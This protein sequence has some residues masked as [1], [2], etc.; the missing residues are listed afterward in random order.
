MNKA[1][2][3]AEKDYDPDG[4]Q[5]PEFLRKISYDQWRD[6]RYE[7]EMALWKGS[8]LFQ[9][10][11]FHPGFIYNRMVKINIIENSQITPVSFSPDVFHYGMNDFKDKV[12][13]NLGFAGFRVRFPINSAAVY[14][15]FLVFLGASYFRAVGQGQSYGLSARGLAVNTAL[16]SGE[17]FPWFREFWLEKPAKEAKTLTIYALLDSASLTGAYRFVVTPGLETRMEV[18]SKLYKRKDVGKLGIAP[19]TSMFLYGEN[20][21]QRPINDFRPEI[22]DSDGLLIAVAA[23][24]WIWQPLINPKKLLVTSFDMKDPVGFG[25]IQRDLNFDHYQDLEA[26]YEQR[27]G[28]WISPR[29]NW[30]KGRLELV[31]IPARHEWDDNIVC[32]WVPDDE[33]VNQKEMVFSY[34]ITWRLSNPAKQSKGVVVATRTAVPPDE[35]IKRF[36]IDFEG[37]QLN[38]LPENTPLKAEVDIKGAELV[39]QTLQKN[40]KTK[41]WRLA[42]EV[43][44]AEKGTLEKVLPNPADSALLELKAYL[45]RDNEVLTETWHYFTNAF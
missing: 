8:G 25:L 12:T 29:E 13:A 21:N 40:P 18:W 44:P 43:K 38:A 17:E 10:E 31:Q 20:M 9:V 34:D 5:V 36:I 15:E 2:R 28:A 39:G 26:H 1:A 30:G 41:G 37:G 7:R 23:E 45:V 4:G 32:Y 19:L 27:P 42:I 6:I 11:F 14:D 35:D 24:D 22:H 3:L 16:D 33:T